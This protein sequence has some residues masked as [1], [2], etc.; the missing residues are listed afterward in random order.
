V[1]VSSGAHPRWSRNNGDG[2]PLAVSTALLKADQQ[3]Y[4]DPAHPTCLTLPI[5]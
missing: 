4:H 1:Q 2:L 3:I 5:C